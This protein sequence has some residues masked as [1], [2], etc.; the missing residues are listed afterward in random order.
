MSTRSSA[1]QHCGSTYRTALALSS[2]TAALHLALEVLGVGRGDEVWCSTLTFAATANAITYVGAT[3]VFVDSERATWNLDPALLARALADAKVKP[4]AV[5]AVDLYGQC[6]DL[7]PIA[8]ACKAHGV[9]L[10]EDAARRSVPR[11]AASRPAR[12]A[13]C[14]SCRSTATRSSPRRAAACCSAATS[15]ARSRALSGDTSAQPGAP[16][17]ARG[18]RLQLPVV[19]LARRGRPRAARGSRSPRRGPACD[20]C[21]LSRRARAT[22]PGWQFMPEAAHQHATFWLT[23]ATV[24]S[25]DARDRLLDALEAADI[26]AR[27]VWKPM[28][29]QPIFA[30]CKSIGGEV[31]AGSV[32]AR[33]LLAER[34]EPDRRATSDGDRARARG[35]RACR[36]LSSRPRR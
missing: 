13:T 30:H 12:T 19:E 7:E 10:I 4:K 32:R 24:G 20:E 17:R 23:C 21:R 33:H 36:R 5:I 6:A 27:P 31:A 35:E 15:A 22:L 11:I 2:G 16:L 29:L 18:D 3:P 1:R 9:Y 14:R 34:V 8:A 25:I 28:H 26:E